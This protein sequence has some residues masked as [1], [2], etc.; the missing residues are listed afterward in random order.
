MP[1]TRTRKAD[2]VLLLLWAD[3]GCPI[4]GMTRLQKLVFLVQMEVLRANPDVRVKF[5]FRPDRFGPLAPELYD[6]IEFLASVGMLARNDSA[7]SITKKGAVF[8]ETRSRP[9]IPD[10]VCEATTSIKERHGRESLDSL[11]KHVYKNYPE[12]ATKSEIL[13]RVLG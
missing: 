8:F 5:E 13:D 4:D 10:A 9:R 7:M 3:D 1:E 6:E 12:F 11:L 2:L